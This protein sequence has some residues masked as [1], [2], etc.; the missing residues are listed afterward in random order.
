MV[1]LESEDGGDR[2]ARKRRRQRWRGACRCEEEDVN[3]E[4]GTPPIAPAF[5]YIRMTGRQVADLRRRTT[6]PPEPSIRIQHLEIR[7]TC[8][9]G[10]RRGDGALTTLHIPTAGQ[11]HH[12]CNVRFEARPPLHVRWTDLPLS[13]ANQITMTGGAHRAHATGP[14]ETKKSMGCDAE[15]RPKAGVRSPTHEGYERSP[16]QP[17]SG[18]KCALRLVP[19]A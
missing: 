9:R 12:D 14:K 5:L 3:G 17:T 18:R 4:R 7:P 16:R 11:A 13:A 19:D 6:G 15:S 1:G 2:R 8:T 10:T